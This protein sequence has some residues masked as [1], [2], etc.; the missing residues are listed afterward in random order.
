MAAIAMAE[1]GGKVQAT[2]PND[3]NGTQT[4]WG[5]W[6]VS[7]GDHTAPPGW[8][9][10]LGNARLAVA[11]L[12]SQGLK[13][14]GTYTSG[15]YKQYLNG[16]VTPSGPTTTTSVLGSIG[17]SLFSGLAS[18]LGLS[19]TTDLF[20]RL[21]LVLMGGVLI[22]VGVIMMAGKPVARAAVTV[23]APEVRT[24]Q[25]VADSGVS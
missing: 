9:T 7:N 14:W 6:Q 12:N 2:N 25:K 22:V 4:S 15:K 11:K 13:A 21:G 8:D 10:A 3:N 1:S 19:S 5:L 20:E 24:A 16:K 23:A 17:G 18:S